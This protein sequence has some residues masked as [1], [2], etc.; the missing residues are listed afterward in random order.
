MICLEPREGTFSLLPH[1]MSDPVHVRPHRAS[2]AWL[3]GLAAALVMVNPLSAAD[4]PAASV[5]QAG[6]NTPP[7]SLVP[8]RTFTREKPFVNS[9]PFLS[10]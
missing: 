6:T 9:P 5:V 3:T 4:V 1:S 2:G 8:I 10:L 7:A